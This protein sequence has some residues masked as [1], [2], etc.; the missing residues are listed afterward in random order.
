MGFLVVI[1]KLGKFIYLFRL[2]KLGFFC[3]D[4]VIVC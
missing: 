2:E 3:G 1:L 4:Y